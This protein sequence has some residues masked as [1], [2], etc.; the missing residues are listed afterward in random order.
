MNKINKYPINVLFISPLLPYPLDDGLKI[1]AFYTINEFLKRGHKVT[2]LCFS[3]DD[4]NYVLDLKKKLNITIHVVKKDVPGFYYFYHIIYSLF[5]RY[6]FYMKSMFEPEFKEKLKLLI[7]NNSFDLLY[8]YDRSMVLYGIDISGLPMI[9]DSVDSQSLNS[10]SGFKSSENV[11]HKLFWYISYIKSK[12]LENSLY[13]KFVSVITISERD[14]KQLRKMGNSNIVNIPSGIDLSYFKPLNVDM[15]PNSMTFLGTMD[16]FSN[17]QAVLYFFKDIYPVI[18]KK[19]P[20]IKIFIIGRNPPKEIL[21][22]ND[23][24]NIFVTGYVEDIRPYVH[25]SKIIISPLR[26]AS[27]LQTKILVSMAMNKP[28]VST[29]V[30]IGEIKKYIN[31]NDIILVRDGKEFAHKV[32]ELFFDDV[33]LNKIGKNGRAIV[34]ENYSWES[35][36]HSVD[37]LIRAILIK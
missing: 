26:M 15:I 37:M 21:A 30:S 33:L 27:G 4:D 17:Q 14:A 24:S 19:I 11:F 12:K 9:L 35:F 1:R 16:A 29:K 25:K 31:Q 23:N 34:K 22:L 3:P 36:G 5:S 13:S 18:K 10:L 28:I 32:I 8:V 6:P 7:S 2:L 20:S